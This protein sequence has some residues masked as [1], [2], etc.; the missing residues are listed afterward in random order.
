MLS[1]GKPL[2]TPDRKSQSPKGAVLRT[3]SSARGI[4]VARRDGGTAARR[5]RGGEWRP[6]KIDGRH[7]WELPRERKHGKTRNVR[8][9]N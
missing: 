5:W 3:Y 6:S 7:K 9:E 1:A 2:E 8:M 4:H